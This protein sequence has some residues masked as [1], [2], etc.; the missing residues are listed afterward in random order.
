MDPL[1]DIRPQYSGNE[2]GSATAIQPVATDQTS[3]RG[4]PGK[5]VHKERSGPP[6]LLALVIGLAFGFL[7]QKG[8]VAKFHVL[9]GMLLLEDFTV[10]RVMLSAIVVGMVGVVLLSRLGLL[11]PQVP[12]TRY[13]GNI[14]GGL[15][16]GIGFGLI[17]YCPGTDAA[18]AGQG[19]FDAIVGILGLMAGSYLFA[20]ASGFLD[21]TVLK[22]GERGKLTLPQAL[23]VSPGLFVVLFASLLVGLL[24]LLEVMAPR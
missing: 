21:R 23:G 11:K 3:E 15:L 12:A 16:F 10:A 8:G 17:A 4:E 19:N 1:K 22:W 20:E 7:L 9:I 13:G 14:L 5:D 18:A 6:L 24:V 2:S